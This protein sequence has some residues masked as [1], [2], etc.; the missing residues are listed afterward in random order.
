M[1]AEVPVSKDE[2]SQ[3]TVASVWRQSLTAIVKALVQHDYS[4]ARGIAGVDPLPGKKAD[5]IERCISD[6]GEELIELPE[7]VWAF[8]ASQWMGTHWEVLI[9]LFT[10]ESGAS[11]L[12]LSVRVHESEDGYRYE[13]DSVHVP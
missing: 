12:V 4:L 7:E 3:H 13:V 1:S 10:K 5:R 2:H 8:S 9:D 11:D 6:Y